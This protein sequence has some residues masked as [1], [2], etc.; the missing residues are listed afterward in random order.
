MFCRPVILC[1]LHSI[2]ETIRVTEGRNYFLRGPH[3]GQ[4]CSKLRQLDVPTAAHGRITICF[5]T[6]KDSRKS[7]LHNLRLDTPVSTVDQTSGSAPA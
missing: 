2:T 3:V 1:V 7:A 5:G 4:P 6:L